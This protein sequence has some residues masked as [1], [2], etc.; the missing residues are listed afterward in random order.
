MLS[1]E[2]FLTS[3]ELF[4][5]P[6][7]EFSLYLS[8]ETGYF[9][10]NKGRTFRY[11]EGLLWNAYLISLLGSSP[12]FGEFITRG[13]SLTIGWAKLFLA[14]IA[15]LLP[16]PYLLPSTELGLT[17]FGDC[18]YFAPGKAIFKDFKFLGQRMVLI[19]LAFLVWSLSIAYF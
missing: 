5:L 3:L 4:L 18:S 19:K 12:I 1:T 8:Y 7:L 11:E 10:P 15:L 2:L 9:F 14:E 17:F 16:L 13:I 6:C